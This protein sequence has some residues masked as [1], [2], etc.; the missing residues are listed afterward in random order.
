MIFPT[1]AVSIAIIVCSGRLGWFLSPAASMVT[2]TWRA[3][4]ML[5]R[6]TQPASKKSV[7][8]QSMFRPLGGWSCMRPRRRPSTAS[9]TELRLFGVGRFLWS[10][11]PSVG[12]S[13]VRLWF[14]IRS[15]CFMP[16]L[17]TGDVEISGCR[18]LRDLVGGCRR[19]KRLRSRRPPKGS[20]SCG[21]AS[22]IEQHRIG[23]AV[24]QQDPP[25]RAMPAGSV[26]VCIRAERPGFATSWAFGAH[27]P[28]C[29]EKAHVF[30]LAAP[31]ELGHVPLCFPS[32]SVGFWIPALCSAT[33]AGGRARSR[34]WAWGSL[35][36]LA[37]HG[38]SKVVG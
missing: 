12:R 10:V 33:V 7:V 11:G 3:Y 14:M 1:R 17:G 9:V 20:V 28:R 37:E 30:P 18:V 4:F 15:D 32:G 2:P 29:S 35:G 16:T 22:R 31:Q 5:A 23:R 38:L 24:S 21:G 19:V 27:S 26:F 13:G 6:I 25:R 34:G 36:A 8:E